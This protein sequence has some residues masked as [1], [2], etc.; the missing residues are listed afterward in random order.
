MDD[1]LQLD[2]PADQIIDRPT[3]RAI[4]NAIC[5]RTL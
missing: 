1:L 5:E 2:L 3:R 4:I